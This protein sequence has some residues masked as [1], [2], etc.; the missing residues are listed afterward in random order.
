MLTGGVDVRTAAGRLGHAQS[1]TT[2]DI[3]AHVVQLADQRTA[4]A[5]G[6]ALDTPPANP[7]ESAPDLRRRRPLFGVIH[8]R[9]DSHGDTPE[10]QSA[11]G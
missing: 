1:S 11:H 8:N 7:I 4:A 10:L 3:Y 2:L 6:A 9:E 5:M